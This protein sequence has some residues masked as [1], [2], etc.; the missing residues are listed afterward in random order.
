M[1]KIRYKGY[2]ILAR[3]YQLS[4]S[5]RWTVDLEIRRN[6]GM[7]P[8]SLD[9]RYPTEREADD[10]CAGLARK[11]IDGK[12]PGWSVE[13]LRAYKPEVVRQPLLAGL[14]ILALGGYL[15]LRGVS[16]DGWRDGLTMPV[17]R[18][19]PE[20]RRLLFGGAAVAAGMVLVTVGSRRR[21]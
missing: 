2:N 8:F 10:R 7:M 12:V 20:E 13:H 17:V 9:E 4:D 3:P 16:L 18:I 19:T 15:L 5:G 11:I 14:I 21:S 6:G 1:T